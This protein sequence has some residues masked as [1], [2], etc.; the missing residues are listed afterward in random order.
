M[1]NLFLGVRKAA[2]KSIGY[3]PRKLCKNFT[4]DPDIHTMSEKKKSLQNLLNHNNKPEDRSLVRSQINRLQKNINKRLKTLQEE[5]A[6]TLAN[7]I[8][9]TDSTRACFAATRQLAGIKR[10]KT[11]SVHDKNDN[12]IVAQ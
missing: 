7:E 5:Q 11:I 6:D 12:L 8:N 10:A 3:L 1:D 2:E 4:N 9:S